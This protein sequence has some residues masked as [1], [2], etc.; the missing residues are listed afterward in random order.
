M[1]TKKPK[2]QLKKKGRPT[3]YNPIKHNKQAHELA[4]LGATDSQIA[5]ALNINESGL[6]RWKIQYPEFRESIKTGKE[7]TDDEV[8]RSLL[9]RAKGIKVKETRIIH[10]PDDSIRTEVIEKEIPPDPTACFFWLKCRRPKEWRD[11]QK[12]ELS[13]KDGSPIKVDAKMDIGAE[14]KKIVGIL[15]DVKL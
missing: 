6:N 11:V 7:I 5:E 9:S 4:E 2:D 3:K 12:M 13:G 8:E 14:V 10:N 15:P 1:T